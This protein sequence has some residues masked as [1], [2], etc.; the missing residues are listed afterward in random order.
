MTYASNSIKRNG[1]GGGEFV[2]FDVR[3]WWY[4]I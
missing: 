3:R 1:E 2:T 4:F